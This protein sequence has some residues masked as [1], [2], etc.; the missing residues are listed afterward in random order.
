MQYKIKSARNAATIS[1]FLQFPKPDVL[2][3]IMIS[4][5]LD[6]NFTI[7]SLAFLIVGQCNSSYI[8]LPHTITSKH[9]L[10]HWVQFTTCVTFCEQL[11]SLHLLAIMHYFSIPT[12]KLCKRLV[13]Q[14]KQ[15]KQ[16]KVP[17]ISHEENFRDYMFILW[18]SHVKHMQLPHCMSCTI[19]PVLVKLIKGQVIK[20][21]FHIAKLVQIQQRLPQ[22]LSA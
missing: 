7:S 5:T 6:V 8:A 14:Q 18:K 20:C 13:Q 9:N 15:I 10:Q 12:A 1:T 19:L 11:V 21:S 3:C 16:K 22:N 4:S 17:Y 2:Y